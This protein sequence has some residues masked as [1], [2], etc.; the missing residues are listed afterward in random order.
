MDAGA[1][2]GVGVA[3]V[4]WRRWSRGSGQ[5]SGGFSQSVC[6]REPC[7]GDLDMDTGHTHWTGQT[8]DYSWNLINSFHLDF[9]GRLI[10][11]DFLVCLI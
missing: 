7:G 8:S 6:V 2:S 4:T 3:L 10:K 1:G 9:L 11:L 5:S